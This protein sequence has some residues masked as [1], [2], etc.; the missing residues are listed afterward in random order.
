M[1]YLQII[2]LGIVQGITEFLPIS[3][4]GHLVVA[5]EV[6]KSLSS[7][8]LPED[9]LLVTLILHQGTL[10]SIL[11]VFHREIWRLLGA[12]RR[13]IPLLILG[14]IPAAVVG[15][16]LKKYFHA[17][18]TSPMLTAFM[19][20]LN[21]L[22]LLWISRRKPGEKS[23]EDIIWWQAL[24]IGL[25]QA[26]APLPGISRSGT[27][28]AA[29]LAL[30]LSRQAA[31]TFSFLLAIPAL[32]GVGVLAL[33]ELID[34]K[35]VSSTPGPLIVGALVS[36]VVGLAALLL[37]LKWLRQGKLAP[38]GWWCIGLG[39]ALLIWQFSR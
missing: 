6:F 12:N 16:T 17:G 30:G 34:G 3:S 37:L 15:L 11:T 23:Y 8:P 19:L 21:G 7:Q 4:D 29:G 39:I 26:I 27:T 31:A 36:F 22:L 1:E 35:Q 38:L 20:P 5:N 9:D 13:L 24:I 25:A 18:L 28:I 14:T 33:R 2:V 32:A 10:L